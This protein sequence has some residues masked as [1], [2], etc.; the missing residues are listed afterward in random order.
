MKSNWHCD[1]P[2]NCIKESVASQWWV[3]GYVVNLHCRLIT[4]SVEVT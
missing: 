4:R 1:I 2:A 3:E